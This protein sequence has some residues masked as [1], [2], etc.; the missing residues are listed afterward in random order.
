MHEKVPLVKL[1]YRICEKGSRTSTKKEIEVHNVCGEY[2]GVQ[3]ITTWS[4]T[5]SG[6]FPWKQLLAFS[7]CLILDVRGVIIE[8]FGCGSMRYS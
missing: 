4:G 8:H 2:N 1:C 6:A 5:R 7:F 3:I